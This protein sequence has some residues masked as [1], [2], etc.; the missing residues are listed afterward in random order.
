[1]CGWQTAEATDEAIDACQAANLQWMDGTM[2]LHNPRAR[3]IKEILSN[4][5]LI[6][7]ARSVLTSFTC[8]FASEMQHYPVVSNPACH[9]V[10]ASS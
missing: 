9:G 5:N 1:M 10:A 6:G 7:S 2:W 4:E 8:D 3:Y